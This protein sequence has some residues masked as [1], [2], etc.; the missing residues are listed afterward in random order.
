VQVWLGILVYIILRGEVR[1]FTWNNLKDRLWL[2]RPTI[3]TGMRSGK[4]LL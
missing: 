3:R 1:P 2:H 4:M